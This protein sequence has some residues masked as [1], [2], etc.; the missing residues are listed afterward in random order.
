MKKYNIIVIDENELTQ[1]ER[2]ELFKSKHAIGWISLDQ[3][4]EGIIEDLE[5]ITE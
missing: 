5:S 3:S 4:R 2:K 1:E